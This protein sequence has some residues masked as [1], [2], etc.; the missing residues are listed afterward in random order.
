MSE[1]PDYVQEVLDLIEWANGPATSTWGAKRA[2]AGHP[3]PFNLQYIGVGNE[4]AQ[5]DVFRERFKMI[6][7][8][9]KAKHPEI[10]V[11]GTVGPFHSGSDYDEGWKFANEQRLEMVDEHYYEK[12][13]WFLNNLKRYDTYDRAKSKV[14]VGEYAAHDAGRANTWRSALAEAAY[15][16]S[17]GT[18]RRRRPAGLVCAAPRQAGPHTVAARHDLFPQHQH[19]AHG[20]L[21]RPT[22]VLPQPWR[23]LFSARCLRFSI[24]E[25][26]FSGNICILLRQRHQHWRRHPQVRECVF[27]RH[28]SAGE[29]FATR[30]DQ[31]ESNSH[32]S[33]GRSQ[34][35]Q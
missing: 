32:G 21:L 15:L 1:M 4:D 35:F 22:D 28:S 13:E 8:A 10:T 3:K 5:T 14:Y 34:S 2:A 26:R 24:R 17:S 18:Q 19:P 9:V 16:T 30:L 20:E 7:D 33:Y 27:K 23:C 31:A 6:H 29:P 12:P 25:R 11:I